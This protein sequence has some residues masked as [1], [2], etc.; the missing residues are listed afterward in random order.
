[1][2]KSQLSAYRTG[3]P[4]DR[5]SRR[6][7][8]A[9]RKTE[10]FEPKAHVNQPWQLGYLK[11]EHLEAWCVRW[12]RVDGS[13]YAVRRIGTPDPIGDMTHEAALNRAVEVFKQE[14]AQ[15]IRPS[16]KRAQMALE[17]VL[18]KTEVEATERQSVTIADCF[19]E[20]FEYL[21][22]GRS[23][24]AKGSM[25]A[26]AHY[27]ATIERLPAKPWG[28]SNIELRN[29]DKP[30]ITK[31][32]QAIAKTRTAATVTRSIG[33]L[34]AGIRHYL[35]HHGTKELA[36]VFS[37]DD[38]REALATETHESER[39]AVPGELVG[40]MLSARPRCR[41][42]PG[43]SDAE[44]SK[45]QAATDRTSEAFMVALRMGLETGLR[46]GEIQAAN[47]EH[48]NGADRLIY[49]ADPKNKK[50][51]DVAVPMQLAAVLDSLCAG[52][53]AHDPLFTQSNGD[54]FVIGAQKRLMRKICYVLTT[55][56]GEP[57][58]IT[59]HQT[60]HSYATN[61]AQAGMPVLSLS[62]QM[63][64]SDLKMLEQTY[65]QDDALHRVSMVDQYA[66]T[67]ESDTPNVVRLDS[68]RRKKSGQ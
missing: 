40:P 58:K 27:S 44:L 42:K 52:R 14:H 11:L 17:A 64:H 61:C 30:K 47:V 26:G 37:Y 63:G 66:T 45:R 65:Y 51:R 54:R 60:R 13:G 46:W 33:V 5:D 2:R 25:S 31:W 67:Y 19:L 6:R 16:E 4:F 8:L 29:L 56:R 32:T 12:Q 41:R 23:K 39:H 9:I 3:T 1:M 59:F 38:I 22:S 48:W 68:K 21:D 55:E 49:V 43:E 35:K 7:K 20:Y 28:I 53:K 10:Y 15:A 57:I 18:S 36:A 34:R 62:K 24:K 50:P